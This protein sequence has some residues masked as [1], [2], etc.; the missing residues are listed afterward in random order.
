MG[1]VTRTVDHVPSIGF[2]ATASKRRSAANV[3][4]RPGTRHV[5]YRQSFSLTY[6]TVWGA[7]EAIASE[8]VA[9]SGSADA[10]SLDQTDHLLCHPFGGGGEGA[11]DES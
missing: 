4:S 8:P 2:C 6:Q 7:R 9:R 10:L 1:T 11:G 3:D 5:W